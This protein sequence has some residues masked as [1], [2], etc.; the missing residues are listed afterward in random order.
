MRPNLECVTG[1]ADELCLKQGYRDGYHDD[2]AAKCRKDIFAAS[3]GCMSPFILFGPPSF[4]MPTP[5]V[6]SSRL[7]AN[8]NLLC[9]E[10]SSLSSA[11]TSHR[12]LLISKTTPY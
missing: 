5:E 4:A 9:R 10:E 11:L 2:R 7:M 8:F 1:R 3:S 12:I 6:Y